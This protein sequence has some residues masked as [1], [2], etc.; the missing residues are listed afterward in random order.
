MFSIIEKDTTD[1]LIKNIIKEIESKKSKF[2][3]RVPFIQGAFAKLLM[4]IY[5]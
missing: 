3:I 4:L 2:K 5:R 1:K